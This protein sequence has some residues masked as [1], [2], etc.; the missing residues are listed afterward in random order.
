MVMGAFRLLPRFNN[1]G[2]K[3]ADLYVGKALVLLPSVLLTISHDEICRQRLVALVAPGPRKP[4]RKQLKM[5][6]S[7]I[8][9]CPMEGVIG[10]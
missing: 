9:R 1:F 4:C 3:M 2:M 6:A 10:M 5:S 8:Q 7:N